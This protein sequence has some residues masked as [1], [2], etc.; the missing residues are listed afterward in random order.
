MEREEQSII[1]MCLLGGH[2]C[3]SL[4]TTCYAKMVCT[5]KG[6]FFCCS[7]VHTLFG[8]FLP[9]LSPFPL[10]VPGRSCSALITNFVEEKT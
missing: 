10:S 4:T 1:A 8:S 5:G 3:G 9:H 7:H 2:V 6:F